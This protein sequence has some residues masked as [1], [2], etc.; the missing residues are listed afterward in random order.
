MQL[1]S[2][3]Q[4]LGYV[5]CALGV[6]AFL[7]KSDARL[8]GLLAVES[9]VYTVHFWLLGDNPAAFIAFLS[10]IRSG[11]AIK[12]QSRMLGIVFLA[13]NL[14]MGV[15]MVHHWLAI[16]PI[17]GG[18][19]GTVAMFFLQGLPMRLV[20]LTS[21]G[22]W[23]ANNIAVGSIGGMVLESFNALANG[24][25]IVRFVAA[26]YSARGMEPNLKRPSSEAI[27]GARRLDDSASGD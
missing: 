23:L 26:R 24:F 10:G 5:A 7:Q 19:L 20:L 1:F 18:V 4:C 27:P 12:T 25:T 21:T 11:L 14:I 13:V 17:L 8:K 16:L 15:P 6:A 22:C 9:F 2:L 3:V